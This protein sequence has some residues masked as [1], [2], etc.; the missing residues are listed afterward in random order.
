[1]FHRFFTS[2]QLS[3]YFKKATMVSISC[4]LIVL[5]QH[6][7]L[8]SYTILEKFAD[9]FSHISFLITALIVI[10]QML[11]L[12]TKNHPNL[13][14]RYKLAALAIELFLTLSVLWLLEITHHMK[15][16]FITFYSDESIA[17]AHSKKIIYLLIFIVIMLFIDLYISVKKNNENINDDSIKEI[18][19]EEVAIFVRQYLVICMSLIGL[20]HFKKLNEFAVLSSSYIHSMFILYSDIFGYMI[21]IASGVTISYY[22]YNYY[23]K[24]SN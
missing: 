11:L 4:L 14:A 18:V 1:M 16:T 19:S 8:P 22:L 5:L 9:F 10:S 12:F 21:L 20:L 24:Q 13:I 17:P 7:Y 3:S 2:Q 15:H 23:S 6:H